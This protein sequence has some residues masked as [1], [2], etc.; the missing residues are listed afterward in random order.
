MR[1]QNGCSSACGSVAHT[2]PGPVGWPTTE[3]VRTCRW[4]PRWPSLRRARI[5]RYLNEH[6]QKKVCYLDAHSYSHT[7]VAARDAG[8]QHTGPAKPLNTTAF[9]PAID[10]G[11][12][13][14]VLLDSLF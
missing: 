1:G 2:S 6:G 7:L 11:M 8:K 4:T 5:H 10:A 13:R 9:A 14:G 3:W 12:D